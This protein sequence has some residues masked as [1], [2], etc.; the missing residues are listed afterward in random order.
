MREGR[1]DSARA[2]TAV[3]V[4]QAQSGRDQLS[5]DKA[6][7]QG[8]QPFC[9]LE[10][11]L[12]FPFQKISLKY[13]LQILQNKYRTVF[14][15]N[16]VLQKTRVV[17]LNLLKHSYQVYIFRISYKFKH[18]ESI[19]T[20]IHSSTFKYSFHS[21]PSIPISLPIIIVL[22]LELQETTYFYLK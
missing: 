11:W 5:R 2:S 16:M 9:Q 20:I 6:A 21:Y 1:V 4:Q 14:S 22:P 7:G 10:H 13:A 3:P 19:L 18:V 8:P 12:V 17:Q 15:Y